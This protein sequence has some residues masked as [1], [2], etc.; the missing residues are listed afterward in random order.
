MSK[1]YGNFVGI[2]EAPDAIFGKLMSIS[3]DLMVRYYELLSDITID[4]LNEL[5]GDM[6]RGTAHPM[7]AKLRFAHEMVQRFHGS[8]AAQHAEDHWKKV[9]REREI[10][11]NIETVRHKRVTGPS[12]LPGLLKEIGMVPSTS[13]GRRVIEQGGVYV[14]G[15]D[16]L[17]KVMGESLTVEGDEL[18]FKVG[19][20]KFKTVVFED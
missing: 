4:E 13:E 15:P 6:K 17:I 8:D 11:A 18:T 3:D 9:H 10:P 2:D 1:T 19:K 7:D 12:W 5:K 20:K 16:G 14:S